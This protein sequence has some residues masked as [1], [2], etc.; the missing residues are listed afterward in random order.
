ML[1]IHFEVKFLRGERSSA[2]RR[3]LGI[4]GAEFLEAVGLEDVLVAGMAGAEPVYGEEGG[5]FGGMGWSKGDR[6]LTSGF[7]EEDMEQ[8]FGKG[9]GRYGHDDKER[10]GGIQGNQR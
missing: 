4:L 6:G 1:I 3:G 10:L 5:A 8:V 7:L 2:V 9:C